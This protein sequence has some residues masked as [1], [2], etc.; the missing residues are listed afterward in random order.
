MDQIQKQNTDV[1][2]QS[3]LLSVKDVAVILGMSE[4]FVY[5]RIKDGSITAVK[6]GR[7]LKI[8]R[9]EVTRIISTG[10]G[11]WNHRRN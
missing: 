9:E 6:F 3:P 2:G 7:R 5:D 11:N 4:D 1:E 8:T 10:L